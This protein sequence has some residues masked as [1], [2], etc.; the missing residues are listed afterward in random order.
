MSQLTR[1][2]IDKIIDLLR[3]TH[4]HGCG[5]DAWMPDHIETIVTKLEGMRS[6]GGSPYR[7]PATE[8]SDPWFSGVGVQTDQG[9]FGICKR[10]DGIEV[11]LDG[12]LVWS[13]TCEMGNAPVSPE[14]RR[15]A[16][17]RCLRLPKSTGAAVEK[18]PSSCLDPDKMHGA[19]DGFGGSDF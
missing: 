14:A 10:D 12:D 1:K 13:S 2:E 18:T 15:A 16:W 4:T 7:Q 3:D 9:L 6:E 5:A 19:G 8:V 11:L 17:S